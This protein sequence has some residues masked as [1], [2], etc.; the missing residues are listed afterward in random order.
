MKTLTFP[1]QTHSMVLA[2]ATHQGS[3][4]GDKSTQKGFDLNK[5]PTAVQPQNNHLAMLPS[6]PSYEKLEK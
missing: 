6:V 2:T 5:E 3:S 4:H 1:L